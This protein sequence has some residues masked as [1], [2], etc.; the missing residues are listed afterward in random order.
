MTVVKPFGRALIVAGALGGSVPR[1]LGA[2]DTLEDEGI[3][4]DDDGIGD[5]E[6]L[7]AGGD[8]NAG[9]NSSDPSD[10]V[11]LPQTGCTM[12]V[13]ARVPWTLAGSVCACL[14]LALSRRR[15]GASRRRAR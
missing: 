2:I 8:P 7:R 9:A 11:P 12:T 1:L 3:D 4:S 10:D 6:E 13:A 5:I 14:V 15:Y